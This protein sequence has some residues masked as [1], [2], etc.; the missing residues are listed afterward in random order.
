MKYDAEK[1]K[2]AL[3]AVAA[4]VDGQIL[5]AELKNYCKWD[6]TVKSQNPYDTQAFAERRGV[7]N[8]LRK[9]IDR[10]YLKKIEYDYEV[11]KNGKG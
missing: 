9:D 10:E 11:I 4:T 2:Q 8:Y 1:Y 7:Y 6:Q 5:L 3:N